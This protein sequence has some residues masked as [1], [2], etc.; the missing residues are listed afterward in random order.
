AGEPLPL[1]QEDVV[2]RGHS[3][4]V[5]VNA[6]DPWTFRPSPGRITGYHAP[7]GPGIRIDAAVH[8]QAVVQPYY[9]SLVA[10][11]I[12]TA[13][14]RERAIQRLRWAMDEFVVEGIST[15]LPLQR[16]LVADPC[17]AAVDFHTRTIDQ[18]LAGRS[19]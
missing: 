19:A 1:R 15:T 2:I 16:L 7:G 14:D 9:D 5:R 18:W 17:F 10:K 12:V 6:E 13:P 3:I 11:L 8:E 4:E